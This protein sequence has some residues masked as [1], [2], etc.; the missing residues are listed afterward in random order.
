MQKK[1]P[2][3]EPFTLEYGLEYDGVVHTQGA[4]RL[5]TLADIEDSLETV[6]EGSCKARLDRYIWSRTIVSLGTIPPEAITPELLGTLA[7]EEYT[8]LSIT[9]GLLRKK[10]KDMKA[11][12]T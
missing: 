2:Q 5:P 11:G 4:L 6:P 10:R 9:E 8:V 12:Q 1:T 7:D 3:T